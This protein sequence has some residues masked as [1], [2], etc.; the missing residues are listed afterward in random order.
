MPSCQGQ[1]HN[2]G[3]DVSEV[4]DIIPTILRVLRTI[5]PKVSARPGP[6]CGVKRGV[7]N[8]PYGQ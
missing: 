2:I 6:P 5:R 3:E 7:E 8:C 1:L 4:P